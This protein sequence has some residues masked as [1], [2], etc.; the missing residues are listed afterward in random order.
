MHRYKVVC[1]CKDPVA[2]RL[3]FWGGRRGWDR[4]QWLEKWVEDEVRDTVG[5]GAARWKSLSLL[6]C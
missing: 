2:K 4:P 3:V 1:M 6:K 5:V